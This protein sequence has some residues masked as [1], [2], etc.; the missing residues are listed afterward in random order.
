MRD[1]I[2]LFPKL[3]DFRSKVL[4]SVQ[5]LSMQFAARYMG[6]DRQDIKAY[7]PGAFIDL[8]EENGDFEIGL[9]QKYG[10]LFRRL[11]VTAPSLVDICLF[12]YLAL[13]Y[14]T[15]KVQGFEIDKKINSTDQILGQNVTYEKTVK[16][17]VPFMSLY[18][19]E[20]LRTHDA[21]FANDEVVVL[22][23]RGVVDCLA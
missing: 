5:G 18:R 4:G 10:L 11:K 22:K 12:D 15:Y 21:V 8:R 23:S 7:Y 16:Q 13:N 6:E 19:D 17:F 1:K 20:L 3:T 9:P 2:A 14:R